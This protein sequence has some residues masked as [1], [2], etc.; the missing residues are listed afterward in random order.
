MQK[1]GGAFSQALS[2]LIES[3]FIVKYVPFGYSK[4]MKHFGNKIK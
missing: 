1:I 3:D 4:R 2:A